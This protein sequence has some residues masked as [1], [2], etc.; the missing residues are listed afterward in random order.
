MVCF[1]YFMMNK[2]GDILPQII[3]Q[4]SFSSKSRSF[5]SDSGTTTIKDKASLAISDIYSSTSDTDDIE[6]CG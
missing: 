1:Y 5:Y 2:D 6:D 3:E 4:S